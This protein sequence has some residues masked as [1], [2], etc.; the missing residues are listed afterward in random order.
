MMVSI[1]SNQD[2]FSWGMCVFF[3]HNAIAHL[4]DC[5]VMSTLYYSVNITFMC[6]EKSNNSCDSLYWDILL[7][8]SLRSACISLEG[9]K[10]MRKSPPVTPLMDSNQQGTKQHKCDQWG[11]GTSKTH[12][13]KAGY[14][15]TPWM[16]RE[17]TDKPGNILGREGRT[18]GLR[19]ELPTFPRGAGE[20]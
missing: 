6:T 20:G 17:K 12:H 19:V 7:I 18:W 11:G 2:F 16:Q 9:T 1:F 14:K 8:A 15:L 13:V 10:M 3:R 4:K 5:T